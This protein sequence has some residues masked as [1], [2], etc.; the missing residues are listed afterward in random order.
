[1]TLSLRPDQLR[2][3]KDIARLL[4]KHA[5][6][7]LFAAGGLE[8]ALLG[9]EGADRSPVDGDPA[10][11]ASE[12]EALGPTF[13][14]LG[15]LL[16]TRSDLLPVPY[17]EALSRLQDRVEPFPWE[18]VRSRVS[19]ELGVRLSKAFRSFEAEPLAAASLGQVHRATLH[20][21]RKVAVKVQRPGIRR[22]ILEDLEA[23]DALAELFDRHTEA[24]RR[25]ALTD[26]L[27]EFRRVLLHE[28]DYRREARNL[29]TLAD[30]LSSF[31]R[32]VVP[33]P[34]ADFTTSQ[35]LTMSFIPGTKITELAS[36]ARL[37]LDGAGLAGELARA[38]IRGVLVDGFFHADPHP[39]NVL[40]T[41][42]HR[43]ALIDLGMVAR[44][45]PRMRERLLRLVV[46]ITGGRGYEAA[47]LSLQVGTRLDDFDEDRYTRRVS[48]LVGDLQDRSIAEVNVG[49]AILELAR[50]AGQ[51]G[52]RPAPELALLGKTM[53]QVNEI[54]LHL[55]PDFEP[56]RI[57]RRQAR[58]ILRHRV[59]HGVSPSRAVSS[60]LEATELVQEL[61]GRLNR[62]FESLL[63]GELGIDIDVLD[64]HLLMS[65]LQ[66]IANRIALGLI[67]AALIVGAA[68]MMRVETEFTLLGYPGI[69]ML[70][71]LA[72]AAC[73]F[74][75]VFN[76]LY[77]DYWQE[78][79]GHR[80]RRRRRR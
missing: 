34:I 25:L 43:L 71:F 49:R 27:E 33:R 14:K 4:L 12:L 21:G 50:R 60:I 5:H 39:G 24:G 80:P 59:L 61:P 46:A 37:D 9:E 74:V 29:E 17:L 55:D 23:F 48:E 35:V 44:I 7:D 70:L 16:S 76:I 79:R 56:N 53:L 51:A 68:L 13:V 1:M 72:A 22:V 45:D 63:R 52:L 66:K 20:D 6:V 41:T 40:V 54:G 31:S 64:E 58:S 67:L 28:L 26:L 15:Q 47:Q 65:N 42:D 19:E 73:G 32:L 62:L 2:R 69:A 18:E 75:L 30:R 10:E 57:V 11:L 3:Y 78:R 77:H 8:R 36:V 38:Y